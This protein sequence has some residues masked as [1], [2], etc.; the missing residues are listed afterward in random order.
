MV[1]LEVQDQE[2]PVLLVLPRG[3]PSIPTPLFRIVYP[4]LILVP[5][6]L[7][8]PLLP[9]PLVVLLLRRTQ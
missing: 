7:R 8:V 1:V 4:M 2:W 9:P 3:Y 5:V 6:V